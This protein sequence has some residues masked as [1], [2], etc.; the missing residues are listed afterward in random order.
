MH[1]RPEVTASV[2]AVLDRMT[3]KA[4]DRRYPDTVTLEDDLEDA[5]AHE[6]A[7]RGHATGEATAVLQTL[8][9]S[10]RRSVPLLLRGRRAVFGTL[11]AILAVAVVLTLV[12]VEGRD[13]IQR[14]TGGPRE[15][16]PADTEAVSVKSTSAVDYDPEG[17]EEEGSDETTRA[18]DPDPDTAWTTES[19]DDPEP[20]GPNGLKSGV[21]LYIDAEP[22]V[23][24]SQ[25]RIKTPD[26]GWEMTLYAAPNGEPPAD[27]TGWTEVGGGTMDSKTEDF[28]LDTGGEPYRYYLVWI[29]SLP[30]DSDEVA[31]GQLTLFREA[32]R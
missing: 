4:L 15:A 12:L 5:L 22:E 16:A 7:R 19:Y 21:G 24:A 30:P 1:G 9:A 2:A 27:L 28:E 17:D 11:L 3:D 25:I 23:V 10:A 29:T 6:A 20:F 14:G 18:T 31:I 32:S 26:P 13:R 8:P